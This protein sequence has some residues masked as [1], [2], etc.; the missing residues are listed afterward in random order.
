[1]SDLRKG[2]PIRKE[3]FDQLF[4][5]QDAL[6]SQVQELRA[7]V[8]HLRPDAAT[9]SAQVSFMG[10]QTH[11]SSTVIC[12]VVDEIGDPLKGVPVTAHVVDGDGSI[13]GGSTQLSDEGGRAFLRYQAGSRRGTATVE[14]TAGACVT[15]AEV[16]VAGQP[17]MVVHDAPEAI[18][19]LSEE[20]CTYAV[21]DDEGVVIED[22]I[23]T[24]EIVSGGG[25]LVGAGHGW[26]SYLA[27]ASPTTVAIEIRAG[28]V[29]EMVTL[30]VINP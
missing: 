9:L 15:T 12:T 16:Y 10:V 11:S 24:V 30:E 2:D 23:S 25:L 7:I 20:R 6:E 18:E 29:S 17:D 3:T 28:G 22:L 13:V 5:R 14:V 21:L 1:M 27:P 19:S 26:F 8:Q 4:R